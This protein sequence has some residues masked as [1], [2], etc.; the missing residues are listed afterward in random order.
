MILVIGSPDD[1]VIARLTDALTH[2]PAP[3]VGIDERA[4][5]RYEIRR[6][7]DGDTVRWQIHGGACRGQRAVD[8]IFVRHA[9]ADAP[10][11]AA[12]EAMRTLRTRLDRLLLSTACAVINRPTAAAAANYSKPYQLRQMAAAGFLVPR[13]LVTNVETAALRFIRD[14]GG[15]VIFKGVSNVKTVPQVLRVPHLGQLSRLANCPT[16]FQEFIA[17]DD[18]RVTVAG[19]A[20][21]ATRVVGGRPDFGGVTGPALP[22]EVLERCRRFTAQQGLGISGIDLRLTPAGSVYAF[23]LNPYPLYTYFESDA[24]R[25]ITGH[26]VRHL[27]QQRSGPSDVSV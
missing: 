26:V 7:V 17:G 12:V 21:V 8:A 24:R 11:R 14:L 23:E 3:F 5:R 19:S 10:K 25:E 27:L 16:Q 6:S 1:P 9:T 15:R 18:F 20:V 13:T 4:P 22:D 2:A